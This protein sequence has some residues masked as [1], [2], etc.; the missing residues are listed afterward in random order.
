MQDLLQEARNRKIKTK[1]AIRRVAM[2][3]PKYKELKEMHIDLVTRTLKY[4]K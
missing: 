1:N 2:A 4:E 3:N